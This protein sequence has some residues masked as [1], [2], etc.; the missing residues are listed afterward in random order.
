MENK[1]DEY[2]LFMQLFHNLGK[3]GVGEIKWS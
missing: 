3:G 1:F 2:V